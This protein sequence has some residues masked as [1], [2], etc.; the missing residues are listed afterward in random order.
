M[1][2]LLLVI[3]IGGLMGV[4]LILWDKIK[5]LEEDVDDLKAE[6]RTDIEVIHEGPREKKPERRPSTK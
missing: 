2:T 4:C 6:V 1:E 5:D 3:P